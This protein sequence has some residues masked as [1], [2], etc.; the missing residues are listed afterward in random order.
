MPTVVNKKSESSSYVTTENPS[1]ERRLFQFAIAPDLVLWELVSASHLSHRT[2][3]APG[4]VR[5]IST[6]LHPQNGHGFIFSFIIF[7]F[8]KSPM[9]LSRGMGVNASELDSLE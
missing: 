8:L 1:A 5:Q 7:S 3:H 2:Q 9:F 6:F 4:L